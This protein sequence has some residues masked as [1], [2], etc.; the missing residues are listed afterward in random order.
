MTPDALIVVCP[1]WGTCLPPMGPAYIA[2]YLEM[3][4]M[5]NNKASVVN[6]N[7]G[8][9][10]LQYFSV[11][12][13]GTPAY[14]NFNGG[15]LVAK[16]DYADFL[17]T[18]AAQWLSGISARILEGGA[19][20]DTGG[21]AISIKQPLNSG[22]ASDGGRTKKGAGSPSLLSTNPRVRSAATRVGAAGGAGG[23]V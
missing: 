7:N 5:P 15:T 9:L 20:I 1:M 21:K 11:S 10:R 4:N 19:G 17:G 2:T 18:G 14:V 13:N 6:L 3:A 22:A 12:S 16:I 8:L 23:M